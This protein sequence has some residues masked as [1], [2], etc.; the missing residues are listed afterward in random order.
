MTE[1][2]RFTVPL[3]QV[4]H[5]PIFFISRLAYSYLLFGFV[6]LTLYLPFLLLLQHVFGNFFLLVKIIVVNFNGSLPNIRYFLKP[7]TEPTIQYYHQ[8]TTEAKM[9]VIQLACIS[10]Y[11]KKPN[12]KL[13]HIVCHESVSAFQL[14]YIPF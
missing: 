1:F 6:I 14:Y 10:Y 3:R 12:C 4:M 9:R 11:D 7:V 13:N 5:S 2:F 8:F